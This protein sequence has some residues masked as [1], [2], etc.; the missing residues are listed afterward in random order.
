MASRGL[1]VQVLGVGGA[2]TLSGVKQ[3]SGGGNQFLALLNDNT[4]VAWG[5][6]YV[7][8]L[9][10]G[11]SGE[12]YNS[13]FPLQVK[14]SSGTGYLS[15]IA[16]VEAGG[17]SSFAIASNGTLWAWGWNVYGQLGDGTMIDHTLPVASLAQVS[18]P[19]TC[20]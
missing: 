17:L 13:P 6:N 20:S 9:G 3:V 19:R 5:E 12:A 8:D 4:V 11:V 18:Q 1:P 7:G 2:G 15:G 14:D 10:Q 16:E